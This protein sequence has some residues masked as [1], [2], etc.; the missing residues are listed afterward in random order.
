MLRI[1]ENEEE[2]RYNKGQVI[3]QHLLRFS[4]GLAPVMMA[5]MQLSAEE[6]LPVI[7]SPYKQILSALA[8]NGSILASDIVRSCAIEE[9]PLSYIKKVGDGSV[10]AGL[11]KMAVTI[12]V[13][14]IP[15]LAAATTYGLVLNK[16][17]EDAQQ[18]G[19][20]DR[21]MVCS[22]LEGPAI[23]LLL[24][25][26]P[27]WALYGA[28]KKLIECCRSMPAKT[29]KEHPQTK[30]LQDLLYAVFCVTDSLLQAELLRQVVLIFSPSLMRLS[31][32]PL[33]PLY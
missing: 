12:S 18:E 33:L 1:N 3:L 30:L 9:Q 26:L 11:R 10:A 14:F 32:T 28:T 25:G 6:S 15:P 20:I 21:M 19:N 13:S 24:V 23:N 27:A 5:T 16:I 7:S 4:S 22:M 2:I 8:V 31:F 29:V 17:G